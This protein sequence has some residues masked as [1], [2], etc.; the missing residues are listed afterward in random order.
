VGKQAGEQWTGGSGHR[1]GGRQ[2]SSG[3]VGVDT[4]GEAG[5]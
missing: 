4:G 3:Q 2:V 1:W 5:R